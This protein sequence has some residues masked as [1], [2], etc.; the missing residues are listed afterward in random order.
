MSDKALQTGRRPLVPFL[1]HP[2][3]GSG[4][5]I[6]TQQRMADL[7]SPYCLDAEFSAGY[8]EGKI[9]S[10]RLLYC[11]KPSWMNRLVTLGGLAKCKLLA[12]GNIGE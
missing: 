5:A 12:N 11:R 7:G 2:M 9:T 4:F 3:V 6:Q 8:N 10:S 1:G